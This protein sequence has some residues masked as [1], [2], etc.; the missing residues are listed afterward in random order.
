MIP[1]GND[2]HAH[3]VVSAADF[4]AILGPLARIEEIGVRIELAQHARDGAFVY[5]FVDVHLLRVIGLNG[6]QHF[7]EISHRVLGI[8]VRGCR[9]PHVWAVNPTQRGRCRHYDNRQN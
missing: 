4:L 5:D 3:T 2:R 7:G 1:A 6:V 8:V 9:G